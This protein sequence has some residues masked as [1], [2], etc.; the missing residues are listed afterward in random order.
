MSIISFH[1]VS[2]ADSSGVVDT[3]FI[4]VAPFHRRSRFPLKFPP[5]QLRE[6]S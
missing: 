1:V 5:G 3:S 2:D 4:L 6:K